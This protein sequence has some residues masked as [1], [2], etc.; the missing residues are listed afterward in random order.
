MDTVLDVLSWI[1]LLG[2]AIFLLIGAI[3]VAAVSGLLYP[4]ACGQ[5]M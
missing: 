1:C 5:R 4:S 3:G 2:G